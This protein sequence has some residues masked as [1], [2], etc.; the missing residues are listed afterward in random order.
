M[1]NINVP[2]AVL[3]HPD[4]RAVEKRLAAANVVKISVGGTLL[5]VPLKLPIASSRN[6]RK[7]AP[8]KR[9]RAFGEA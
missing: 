2:V 3:Q 8:P 4:E 9:G 7:I 6:V 5:A 1:T